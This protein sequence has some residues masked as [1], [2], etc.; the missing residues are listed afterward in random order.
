MSLNLILNQN[1]D[2]VTYYQVMRLLGKKHN[3]KRNA[4]VIQI[5]EASG[6]MWSGQFSEALILA[7]SLRKFEM[8]VSYKLS[9][10]NICFICYKKMGDLE[11]AM[12]VKRETEALVTTFIKASMQKAG[13][14]LLDIMAAWLCG[15]ETMRHSAAWRR[16]AAPDMQQ[17]FKRRFLPYALRMRIFLKESSGMPGRAWNMRYKRE[18]RCTLWK[19]LAVCWQSWKKGAELKCQAINQNMDSDPDATVSLRSLKAV[20]MIFNGRKSFT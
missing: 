12:Q 3:R 7:E 1:C 6:L 13:Q 10:L 20:R 18:G 15:R 4:L 17:N 11:R 5:N 9:L 14:E 2:P 8:S 16:P 19:R